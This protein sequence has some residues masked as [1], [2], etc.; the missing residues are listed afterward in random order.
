MYDEKVMEDINDLSDCEKVSLISDLELEETVGNRKNNSD[1]NI[2]KKE[3]FDA[4]D[5]NIKDNNLGE[6][7]LNLLKVHKLNFEKEQNNG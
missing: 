1:H 7:N 3:M 2:D 6:L 5:D 4:T